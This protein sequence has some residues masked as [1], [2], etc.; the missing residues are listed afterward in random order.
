[1][2]GPSPP[3]PLALPGGD[4]RRRG[5][6]D[7]EGGERFLGAEGPGE[8]EPPGGGVGR[9]TAEE[10]TAVSAMML[11]PLVVVR[12]TRLIWALSICHDDEAWYGVVV[13][14]KDVKQATDVELQQKSCQALSLQRRSLLNF[15]TTRLGAHRANA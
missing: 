7:L 15:W 6:G 9:R 11:D 13:F 8:Y 10:R 4:L 1:V 12:I 3:R 14:E 5:E 2:E